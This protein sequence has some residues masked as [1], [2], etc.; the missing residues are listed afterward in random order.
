[1][2]SFCPPLKLFTTLP[3]FTKRR[4]NLISPEN[5][6]TLHFIIYTLKFNDNENARICEAEAII[7]LIKIV[8]FKK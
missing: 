5:I 4:A 1:M 2:F 6:P 3:I 7:K 8:R